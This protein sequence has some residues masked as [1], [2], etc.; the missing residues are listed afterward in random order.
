MIKRIKTVGIYLSTR[1]TQA[2]GSACSITAT[3]LLNWYTEDAPFALLFS[4]Y[5]IGAS[6]WFA[7]AYQSRNWLLMCHQFAF[8]C[9]NTIGLLKIT[10]R[11]FV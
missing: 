5:I 1:K 10:W 2:I 3:V 9:S 6:C 11:L 4:M 7:S 8:L